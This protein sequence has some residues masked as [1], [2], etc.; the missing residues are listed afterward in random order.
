MDSKTDTL[1]GN[2]NVALATLLSLRIRPFR[3]NYS[4]VIE[5]T[6]FSRVSPL[7]YDSPFFD[8]KLHRNCVCLTLS[9]KL[10]GIQILGM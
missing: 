3:V 6:R 1:T 8:A 5:F 9:L 10:P 4:K 7:T 2:P